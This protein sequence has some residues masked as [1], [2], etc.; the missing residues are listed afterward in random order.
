[1]Y[2]NNS[3]FSSKG[4]EKNSQAVWSFKKYLPTFPE[5]IRAIAFE[6]DE[7]THGQ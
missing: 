7:N 6:L 3:V 4:S 1:M 2:Y 5:T